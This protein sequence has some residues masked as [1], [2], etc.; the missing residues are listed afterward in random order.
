MRR[1]GQ[2]PQDVGFERPDDVVGDQK[3]QAEYTRGTACP[4]GTPPGNPAKRERQRRRDKD[5]RGQDPRGEQDR[6]DG[7][8]YPP[9]PQA[10]APVCKEFLVPGR[11]RGRDGKK[12][13]GTARQEPTRPRAKGVHDP[14]DASAHKKRAGGGRGGKG[15]VCC[16]HSTRSVYSHSGVTTRIH[17]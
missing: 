11:S 7:A 17:T 14:A 9:D 15:T 10:A 5:H 2:Q 3:D 8:T 6:G 16:G 12:V 4:R 1:S 13:S